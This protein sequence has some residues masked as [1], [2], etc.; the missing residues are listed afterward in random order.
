MVRGDL[1]WGDHLWHDRTHRER[2]PFGKRQRGAS[3]GLEAPTTTVSP[4]SCLQCFSSGT[5]NV[6]VAVVR[7]QLGA[8]VKGELG[9]TY[10]DVMLDSGS[11]ISLIKESLIN[12]YC[13]NQDPPEGLNLVSAAGEPISVIGKVVAP[14]RVGNIHADHNFIVVHSLITPVIL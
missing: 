3:N 10:V 9:N 8:I 12:G 1:F 4:L 7:S 11:S 6:V 13:V 5:R 14:I 2:V